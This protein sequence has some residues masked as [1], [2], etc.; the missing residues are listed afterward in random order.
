MNALYHLHFTRNFCQLLSVLVYEGNRYRR[1]AG[2]IDLIRV[3]FPIH[4]NMKLNTNLL[5]TLTVCFGSM[6]SIRNSMCNFSM[7]F[8]FRHFFSASHLM[9]MHWAQH[10]DYL[11]LQRSLYSVHLLH[12]FVC[13][14]PFDFEFGLTQTVLESER[15]WIFG[16]F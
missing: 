7:Q 13:A 11:L 16:R 6:A 5:Y 15:M 14:H 10:N 12:Y 3:F 4:S 9:C 8:L 1:R 2:H